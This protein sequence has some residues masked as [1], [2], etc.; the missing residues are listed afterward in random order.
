MVNKK[1]ILFSNKYNIT[2]SLNKFDDMFTLHR[3][4]LISSNI[5]HQY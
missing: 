2:L 3:M 4:Y 1:R 5:T